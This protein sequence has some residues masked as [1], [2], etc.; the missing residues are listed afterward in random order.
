[1]RECDEP[2]SSPT[3]G[4]A[5]FDGHR[6]TGRAASSLAPPSFRKM[7]AA[8]FFEITLRLGLELVPLTNHVFGLQNAPR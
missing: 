2:W 4:T 6:L 7:R 8:R 5:T 1:M 3:V